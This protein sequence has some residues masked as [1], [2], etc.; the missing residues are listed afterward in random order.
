MDITKTLKGAIIYDLEGNRM[1]SKVFD[2]STINKQYER[3][4][5]GK[6]R[7]QRTKDEIL[8]L[9]NTLVAHKFVNQFH[10]YIV[11][12]KNENPL[13]LDTVLECLVEVITSLLNKSLDK[14]TFQKKLA[15]VALAFDEICDNGIIL[16]TDSDLVLQRVCLK[17]DLAEQTLAQKLQ[18]AT[19]Q[20]K[21]PWIRSYT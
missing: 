11:G 19:E 10:F 14:Q 18:S 21:F 6:T 2:D 12:N 1:F 15:Q 9:D 3:K 4:L 7:S 13:V 16:E 17:E 8:V 20:F 5:F